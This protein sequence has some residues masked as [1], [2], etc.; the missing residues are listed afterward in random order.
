M[1]LREIHHLR[2]SEH[3]ERA[4]SEIDK[5]ENR[6]NRVHLRRCRPRYLSDK[7]ATNNEA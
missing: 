4:R 3:E 1:K 7:R 2:A 6:R 5:S